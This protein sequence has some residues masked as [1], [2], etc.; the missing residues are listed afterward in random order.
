MNRQEWAQRP[1]RSSKWITKERRAAI[2]ARDGY[3]CV[4]CGSS[5]P[6]TLD[7][8]VPRSAGGSHHT[9]NLLTACRRC[10][11]ARGALALAAF[12]RAVGARTGEPHYEIEL[13]VRRARRRSY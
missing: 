11:C 2:Y 7:H 6:L 1:G 13:R 4:Y 8:A 3:K 10:N 9:N 12:C 5:G